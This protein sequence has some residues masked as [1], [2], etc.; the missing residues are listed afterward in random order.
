MRHDFCFHVQSSQP[1]FLFSDDVKISPK[2]H[3]KLKSLSSFQTF[4]DLSDSALNTL[5]A[6]KKSIRIEFETP[7]VKQLE[8]LDSFEDD[9]DFAPF[10][11]PPEITGFTEE[12]IENHRT[13]RREL[14]FKPSLDVIPE[15][16]KLEEPSK[17]K[18]SR[19]WKIKFRNMFKNW[20]LL[21]CFKKRR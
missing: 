6:F 14:Y 12:D 10:R 8:V 5:Q 7:P 13:Y 11:F 17:Q 19:C 2:E 20:H 21:C 16:E 9:E 15:E 1:T 3:N 18:C 4:D